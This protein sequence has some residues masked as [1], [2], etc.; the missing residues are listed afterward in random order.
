MLSG[1]RPPG[2]AG[3]AE[4]D[5]AAGVSTVSDNSEMKVPEHAIWDS[6]G[7]R[8]IA[9]SE[10]VFPLPPPPPH[11]SLSLSLL[12]KITM[13]SSRCLSFT[14]SQHLGPSSTLV[15]KNVPCHCGCLPLFEVSG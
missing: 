2:R 10:V 3:G 8:L 7:L 12:I 4:V 11:P 15:A 14:T 1:R 5:Q 9:A 13:K 6:V